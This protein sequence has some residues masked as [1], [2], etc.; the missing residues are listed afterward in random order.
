MNAYIRLV[1]GEQDADQ[2]YSVEKG[3]TRQSRR[4]FPFVW[5]VSLCRLLFMYFVVHNAML[6]TL[7][8]GVALS[9]RYT[10][11][12]HSQNRIV[13]EKANDVWL[14][15]TIFEIYKYSA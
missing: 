1:F 2:K 14:V 8:Y 11:C 12:A 15:D 3:C 9:N 10:T 13:C 4:F 5:Y 7:Y 6:F